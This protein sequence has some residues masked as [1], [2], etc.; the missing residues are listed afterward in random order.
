MS[1]R[2]HGRM[3]W[4]RYLWLRLRHFERERSFWARGGR[5]TL[6]DQSRRNADHYRAK[7]GLPA[8]PD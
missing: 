3:N 2:Y 5:Y 8:Q 1:V 4:A 7:L 6:C